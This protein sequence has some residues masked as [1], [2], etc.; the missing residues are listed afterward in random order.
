MFCRLLKD[1]PKIYF[2][3]LWFEVKGGLTEDLA[4][5]V[6]QVVSLPYMMVFSGIAMLTLG[7]LLLL[8]LAILYRLQNRSMDE[9]SN[10]NSVLLRNFT[11]KKK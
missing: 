11:S 7:F 9:V 3:I 4:A 1:V 2:P 10:I 6:K 8:S 5:E